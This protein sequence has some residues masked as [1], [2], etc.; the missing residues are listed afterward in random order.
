MRGVNDSDIEQAF[1]EGRILR[2][3]IMRPTW[4]FVAP[5]DLRWMM[6]LTAARVRQGLGSWY[7]KIELDDD[8]FAKSNHVIAKALESGQHLTRSELGS[9]LAEVGI[10]AKGVRL[11]FIMMQAE[12]DLVVCSGSRR[13][14]HHTYALVDDC[15]P[16]ESSMSRDEA[17]SKLTE[18]YFKAH[19]PAT[20][21]DFAWWSGLT[22]SD[23]RLGIEMVSP[24]LESMV[25]DDETYWF[26]ES[27]LKNDAV[28]RAF[29]LP[30]FDEYYVGYSGFAKA[31]NAGRD[32][33]NDTVAQSPIV[34]D[35]QV[36]G[37][38]RRTVKKNAIHLEL[39]PFEVFSTHEQ[40]LLV[41]AIEQYEA[42]VG[43]RVVCDPKM[44]EYEDM[45]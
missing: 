22:L 1:N 25:I 16:Q 20:A 13:G 3:H 9:K 11:S 45:L 32:L 2:T 27:P 38:W 41:S 19:G 5:E 7:R 12:L 17:L 8:L 26:S 10:V 40:R 14:K 42:F 30:L 29:L 6:G 39:T 37:T 21:H 23:A 4:H 34:I 35:G 36:V 33:E 43:M 18:R 31:V 44:F 28:P 15:V 24:A